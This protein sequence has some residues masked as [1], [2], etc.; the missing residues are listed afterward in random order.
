MHHVPYYCSFQC[1]IDLVNRLFRVHCHVGTTEGHAGTPKAQVWFARSWCVC[2]HCPCTNLVST[3]AY[4]IVCFGCVFGHSAFPRASVCE[5]VCVFVRVPHLRIGGTQVHE[6]ALLPYLLLLR[7]RTGCH[8][9]VRAS[10]VHSNSTGPRA[11]HA[12]QRLSA[13]F[14]CRGRA[15]A[16]KRGAGTPRPRPGPAGCLRGPSPLKL[17]RRFPH[18]RDGE[19]AD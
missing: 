17:C 16:R 4:C 3:V 6:F 1:V 7:G 5:C 2:V 11:L 10:T 9:M 8:T 13:C 19:V 14:A 12:T 18:A 15:L